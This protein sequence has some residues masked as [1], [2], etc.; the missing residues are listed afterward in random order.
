MLPILK[1]Y[2]DAVPVNKIILIQLVCT[3]ASYWHDTQ[4]SYEAKTEKNKERQ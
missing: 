4:E 3:L 2:S 1:L